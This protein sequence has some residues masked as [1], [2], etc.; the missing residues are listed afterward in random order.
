MKKYPTPHDSLFKK[1][2][3]DAA[4]A[5]DFLELYMPT[6]LRQQC[7]FSTLAIT[8][9]SFVEADLRTQRSDI[10]YRLQTTS[11]TGYIYCL[12]EHQSS[13][14]KMMA[15]RLMRYSIAAMHRHLEQGNATLPLVIPLLFYH[16]SKSPYPYSTRWLD[17]FNNPEQAEA[18]Y[19]REFPLVDITVIPDAEIKTH[20]KV[21]LLEYVQ[22]HIRVRDFSLYVNDF[23]ALLTL[24][25]LTK[26]HVKA[27]FNYLA[28]NANILDLEEFMANLSESAS[29]YREEVM[30][31]AEYLAQKG[32]QKG[33]QKGLERGR[34]ET[35]TE[36]ARKMLA[37]GLE[38]LAVMSTT[39][40]TE[41]ELNALTCRNV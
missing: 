4:V 30:T 31:I 20:K 38:P 41:D 37:I 8:S 35:R 18:L 25:T 5:R 27:L 11:G 19:N 21:G 34:D 1:L 36:I 10:L 22:K 39:G 29:S 28:S 2:F 40:F 23:A 24:S 15:F 12:I 26:E 32:M 14:D 17:C 33:M 7:D 3:V 16:G 9:D 13:P 6:P